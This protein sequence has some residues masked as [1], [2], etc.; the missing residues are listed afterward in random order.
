MLVDMFQ[1]R[2]QL[3]L[4]VY[5]ASWRADQGEDVR[6]ESYMCKYFGDEMSFQA[7]DRCMQ[8]HGGMGLT[9]DLPIE[10]FFRDQRSMVITEGPTEIL[11]MA[12][13]RQILRD[14]GE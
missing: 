2:H 4:M 14:Y 10:Q 3:Q 5:N 11:K 13:A 9:K 8:I 12:L 1:N 7:A 6:K